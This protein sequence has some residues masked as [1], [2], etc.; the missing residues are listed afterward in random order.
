LKRTVPPT[1]RTRRNADSEA[2]FTLT[3][4]LAGLLVASMLIVGL[5]DITRRYAQTMTRMKETSQELRAT[6]AT[7]ALMA[8][9][10]RADPD[11]IEISSAKISARIGTSEIDARLTRTSDTRT[12]LKWKS[13][14]GAREVI[15]PGQVAFERLPHG[16]IILSV[17]KKLPPLAMAIPAR[18]VHSD[19]QYDTVSRACR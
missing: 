16:A 17:G 12:S 19:C 14:S 4:L 5:A 10:E 6:Y 11:S 13:P 18:T 3:E 1:T 2:G 15:L 7:R 8:D 9:L